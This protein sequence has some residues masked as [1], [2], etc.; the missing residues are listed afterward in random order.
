MSTFF[1]ILM[2][3]AMAMTLVILFT[4]LIAM[5]RGGAFNERWGNRLMRWR[6]L[7]QAIA[8][9]LFLIGFYGLRQ[10]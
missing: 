9:A 6:I 3:I 1:F 10:G 8:L 4:G 5:A 7:A 2:G